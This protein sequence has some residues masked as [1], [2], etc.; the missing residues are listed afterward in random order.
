MWFQHLEVRSRRISSP[1]S[2]TAETEASLGYIK[3]GGGGG[4]QFW[5]PALESL[6]PVFTPQ[7]PHNKLGILQIPC[8]SSSEETQI[9][10][11]CSLPA[12]NKAQK[13]LSARFRDRCHLRRKGRMIKDTHTFSLSAFMKS[14]HARTHI[15]MNTI[16]I[17]KT[18]KNVNDIFQIRMQ[19]RNW[20]LE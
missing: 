4:V 2:W 9:G 11:L 13:I 10:G 20:K 15:W 16:L 18:Q 3:C 6:R 17:D 1:S 19:S 7:H 8:I 12:S 14:S 5:S